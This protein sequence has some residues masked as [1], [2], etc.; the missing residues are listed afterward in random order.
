MFPS[1]AK[2]PKSALLSRRNCSGADVIEQSLVG[3]ESTFEPLIRLALLLLKEKQAGERSRWAGYISSLPESV[4]IA[5]LWPTS[6]PARA[7]LK[8]TPADAALQ[9]QQHLKKLDE[10]YA[11]CHAHLKDRLKLDL[12][13]ADLC[14]AYSIVSS[15]A[16]I[17][18]LLASKIPIKLTSDWSN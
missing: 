18:Q 15:R 4:P 14:W 12:S 1:A 6:S 2:I 10:A 3:F 13:L 5:A 7:W 17:G 9:K 8:G 11:S 16:F